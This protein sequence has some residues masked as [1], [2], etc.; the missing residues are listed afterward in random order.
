LENFSERNTKNRLKIP[1]RYREIVKKRKK[2]E[3][4]L[5]GRKFYDIRDHVRSKSFQL[6]ARLLK[7]A[8]KSMSD[9]KKIS[10]LA[11]KVLKVPTSLEINFSILG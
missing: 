5:I 11:G 6:S 2:I 7:I 3:R 8:I 1:Y 10:P 9:E 4:L